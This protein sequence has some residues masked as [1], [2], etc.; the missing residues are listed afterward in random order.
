MKFGIGQPMR[1]HED[2]RLITGQGRYTDD[3]TL[4]RMAQA[5]VLRSPMAHAPIKRV[6]AAAARRM[7]GVLLVLTGEDVRDGWPRR[8]PLH[9]AA[10]QPRRQAAARHAASGAC[11]RQGP[12]RRSAGCSGRRRDL[13][14]GARCRR[15]HRGRLRGAAVGHRDEGRDRARRG[16]AF[17]SYSRQP[18][19]RLG[20]R[21]RRRQ[22]D[23]RRLRQGRTRRHARSRQQSRCRQL[24][25]AAQR[26]WRLRSGERP[27]DPLH[28]DARSAFRARPARRN[29]AQDSQ[30]ASSA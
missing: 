16:A 4:P 9:D 13:G 12:A 17:R 18:G 30:R 27:L 2:L 14:G 25:G 20:Q 6:D 1:R 8:R 29:R 23:R 7:P 11:D 19:V 22:G 26:H 21:P 5:F 28:R 24:D 10:R 3:I 15:G